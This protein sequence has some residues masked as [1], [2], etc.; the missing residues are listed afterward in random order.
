[1]PGSM[2]LRGGRAVDWIRTSVL[3]AGFAR[4]RHHVEEDGIV[5]MHRC[6]ET[7]PGPSPTSI[8]GV[9]AAMFFLAPRSMA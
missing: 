4:L 7:W 6:Y 3:R 2:R 1:M 9:I 5:R 8:L